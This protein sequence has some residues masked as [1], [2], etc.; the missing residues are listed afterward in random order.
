[1][2]PQLSSCLYLVLRCHLNMMKIG[3]I[4]GKRN[5][6]MY[7]T[8]AHDSNGENQQRPSSN[9][10]SSFLHARSPKDEILDDLKTVNSWIRNK[11]ILV[12]GRAIPRG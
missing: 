7:A 6:E 1:M 5:V 8:E 9:I 12:S 11:V 4:L 3:W 2:R 10:K